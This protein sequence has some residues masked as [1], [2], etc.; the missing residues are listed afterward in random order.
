MADLTSAKRRRGVVKASVTRLEDRIRT[1]ELKRE[2]SHADKITIE[3]LMKKI[4]EHDAQFKEYHLAIVDLSEGEEQLKLEQATLNNHDD[5]VTDFTDRLQVLLAKRDAVP[6]VDSA[7]ST[8]PLGK[9]LDRIKRKI[10]GVQ[11]RVD[12][13]LEEARVDRCLLQQLEEQA[14]SLK[15]DLSNVGERIALLDEDRPDLA[16]I[17]D[18]LDKALFKLSLQIKR[19]LNNTPSKAPSTSD[20]SGVKLPRI[21]VPTFDDN[22]VNWVIFWEQFE[23]AIHSKH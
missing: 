12:S 16:D 5:R 15:R 7:T 1:L 13:A 6:P 19:L 14:A 23:A 9:Q 2:L 22:I 20:S 4:D 3:R 21:D 11:G 10:I 17:E 8:P 18:T